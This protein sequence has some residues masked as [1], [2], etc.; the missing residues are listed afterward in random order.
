MV[1]VRTAGILREFKAFPEPFKLYFEHFESL[2]VSYP[3]DISLGYLFSQIE[4]A[5]NMSLYGG[6][7]KLHKVDARLSKKAIDS[8]HITRDRFRALYKRIMGE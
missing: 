6:V 8:H 5:Q 2:A 4:L 1:V 3:W 7:V